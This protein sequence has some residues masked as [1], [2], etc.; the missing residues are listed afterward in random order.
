MDFFD[1][2]GKK[3]SETY[4]VASEKT[5]K[6]AREAKLKISISE[7]KEKIET[8]Y[9]NIGQKLYEKYLNNRGDEI[10]L[11][12]VEEFKN[13]DKAKESIKNFEKEILDLKDKKKCSNCANEYE[14][15]Y[16]FC[17]NCGTKNEK[18]VFEAEVVDKKEENE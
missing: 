17:P 14:E 12:F 8:A 15:K 11:A 6:L 2:I 4:N 5:T 7:E 13:V 1:K 10:A 18:E 16:D 9:R 3:V